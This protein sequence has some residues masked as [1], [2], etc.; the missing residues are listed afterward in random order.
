[1]AAGRFYELRA[2]DVW[3]ARRFALE[4]AEVTGQSE[5]IQALLK[6]LTTSAETDAFVRQQ[7]ESPYGVRRPPSPT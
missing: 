5:A 6:E 2:G 7:L 1:M 4:T 3:D